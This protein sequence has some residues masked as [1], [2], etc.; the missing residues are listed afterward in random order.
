MLAGLGGALLFP[1]LTMI[2]VGS[3]LGS[4]FMYVDFHLLQDD[5]IPLS[6]LIFACFW[7]ACAGNGTVRAA[8]WTVPVA[9]AITVAS[10]GGMWL[11][12]IW[13]GPQA[14]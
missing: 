1:V 7:C 12:R 2:G 13:R 11:G 10:A 4:P 5:L 9:I 6:I 3:F 14:H 8:I